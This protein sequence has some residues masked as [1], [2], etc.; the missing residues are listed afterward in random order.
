MWLGDKSTSRRFASG[1]SW[2]SGRARLGLVLLAGF[3]VS[4]CGP[5]NRIQSVPRGELSKLTGVAGSLMAEPDDDNFR[6]DLYNGTRWEISTVTIAIWTAPERRTYLL[7]SLGG[8]ESRS[9]IGSKNGISAAAVTRLGPSERMSYTTRVGNFIDGKNVSDDLFLAGLTVP[10]RA[11]V[12]EG[13][14]LLPTQKRQSLILGGFNPDH[15]DI[16][17]GTRQAVPRQEHPKQGPADPSD[18]PPAGEWRWA[19]IAAEGR[20]VR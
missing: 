10:Q 2:P 11:L 20:R 17:D 19:L 14:L 7:H 13:K 8:E 1:R 9:G 18:S 6:V 3:L 15:Y 12:R 4:G 16:Q 5:T